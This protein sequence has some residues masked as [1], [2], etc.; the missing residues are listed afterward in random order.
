[1]AVGNVIEFVGDAMS[2]LQTILAGA[3]I[4]LIVVTIVWM[5]AAWLAAGAVR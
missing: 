5:V 3:V 1:M 4:T 2:R